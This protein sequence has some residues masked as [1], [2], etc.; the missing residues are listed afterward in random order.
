MINGIFT[1]K[2]PNLIAC[3]KNINQKTKMVDIQKTD[4]QC[5]YGVI[6]FQ[7]AQALRNSSL[8]GISFGAKKNSLDPL[9]LQTK[10]AQKAA[11]KFIEAKLN[12][13]VKKDSEREIPV[14]REIKKGF[15][16]ELAQKIA[17]NPEK[18][19]KLAVAGESAS[20][21]TSFAKHVL[22]VCEGLNQPNLATMVSCDNYY[23]PLPGKLKDESLLS[24]LKRTNHNL[25]APDAVDLARFKKEVTQVANGETIKIPRYDFLTS[26]VIEN[27]E[28]KKPAKVLIT[29]GLFTL[30]DELKDAF[31]VR[32]YVHRKPKTIKRHW[33]ERAPQR[34]N[35]KEEIDYMWKSANEGS[36]QFVRPSR[37]N[38]DIVINRKSSK[39]DRAAVIKE[40]FETIKTSGQFLSPASVN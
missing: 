1:E 6:S 4:N 24:Y 29:E 20:G 23:K 9:H 25:D 40:I 21:K 2:R 11:E 35:S 19:I 30:T 37:A 13:I 5:S 26:T 36:K 15:I 3:N 8:G 28:E 7:G 22:E 18:T 10:I 33:F 16:K 27:A 17:E 34:C 39:E 14:F 32:I 38:A 12:E 31:D